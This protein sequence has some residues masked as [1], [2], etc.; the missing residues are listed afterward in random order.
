[1]N[2]KYIISNKQVSKEEWEEF[3]KTLPKS[4]LKNQ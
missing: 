4:E 2:K 3:Y 1:V